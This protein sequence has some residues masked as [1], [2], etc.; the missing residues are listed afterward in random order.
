[1]LVS[2]NNLKTTM[3]ECMCY[4]ATVR[5]MA[6]RFS[7]TGLP[8]LALNVSIVALVAHYVSL[9]CQLYLLHGLRTQAYR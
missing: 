5:R 6:S 2:F 1:M 7:N 4:C 8:V 9:G 3:R